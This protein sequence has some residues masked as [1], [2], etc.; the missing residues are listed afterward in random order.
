MRS[1]SRPRARR[2]MRQETLMRR[3]AQTAADREVLLAS[4][5]FLFGSRGYHGT[6]MRAIASRA[7]FSMGALYERFDSKDA[8]YCEVVRVHFESIWQR[9]DRALAQNEECLPRLLAI[10]GA[11][12][13][14]VSE[15][16]S[17]LRVYETHPPTLSEPYQSR[18]RRMQAQERARQAIAAAMVQGQKAGLIGPGDPEFLGQMYMAMVGRAAVNYLGGRQ[19]LPR[20]EAI[21]ELFF[22]GAAA[23]GGR[24]RLSPN[25][26]GG[27]PRRPRR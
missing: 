1:I 21:A 24:R 27:P 3:A 15:H 5:A 16:R 19:P 8:M 22:R 10:T 11:I 13:D 4:A 2:K 12:F 9:L 26:A 7:G 18:I 6:S 14:H 17:F 25:A 23:R 20:L